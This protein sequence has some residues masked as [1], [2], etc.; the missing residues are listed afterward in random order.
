MN[1]DSPI[2]HLFPHENATVLLIFSSK[3]NTVALIN[4]HEKHQIIKLFSNQRISWMETEID[5]LSSIPETIPVPRL[6]DI[7]KEKQYLLMEYVP[8]ENLC[9]ILNDTTISFDKKNK[10]M[11]QLAQ[12][13]I[14]FHST[15]KTSKGYIIK[16]DMHIR[17]FI[18][19]KKQIYGVDF[20]EST[21]GNPLVDIAEIIVSLLTTN[22]LFTDEKIKLCTSFF[23]CLQQHYSIEKDRFDQIFQDTMEKTINRRTNSKQLSERYYQHKQK[24]QKICHL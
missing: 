24:I 4:L 2:S 19:S 8:G 13:M 15:M 10:W 12:W 5:M 1:N 9:D 23:T 16:G 11:K 18:C 21:Q 3:K 14:A 20:E 7:N 22:P 6:L 17:N